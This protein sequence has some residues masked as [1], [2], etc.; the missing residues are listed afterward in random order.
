[1]RFSYLSLALCATAGTWTAMARPIDTSSSSLAV[2]DTGAA[3]SAR[4][5]QTSNPAGA[6]TAAELAARVQAAQA[7][8]QAAHEHYN[9]VGNERSLLVIA[10]A[11]V[12]TRQQKQQEV[13]AASQ[14]VYDAEVNLQQ[15][16]AA[17]NSF[18][19]SANAVLTPLTPLT[20][21]GGGL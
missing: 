10:G 7:A 8:V 11:P 1:M 14:A 18:L 19:A 15:A 20:P 5:P 9:K 2:R 16:L 6:T 17:Y 21:L 12:A 4:S 3:L 13:N